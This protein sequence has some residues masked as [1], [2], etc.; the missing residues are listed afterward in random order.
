MSIKAK[1]AAAVIAGKGLKFDAAETRALSEAVQ[2]IAAMREDYAA[3]KDGLRIIADA[4]HGTL[5]DEELVEHAYRVT[6]E[7]GRQA[8]HGGIDPALASAADELQD[9]IK[10]LA[11]HDSIVTRVQLRR[12]DRSLFGLDVPYV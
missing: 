2:A 5:T 11:E 4:I 10:D 7:A 6:N 9:L 3:V 1:L 12:L 8:L